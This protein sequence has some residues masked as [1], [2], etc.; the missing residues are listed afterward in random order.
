MNTPTV[1]VAYGTRNGSTEGIA[2]LIGVA[3]QN[4]G[5]AVA[6]W[7]AGEVRDLSGYDAVVLG[8]ALYRH[9][10]VLARIPVCL[11]SSGPLDDSAD[12]RDIPPVSQVDEAARRFRARGHV[13]F[14]GRLTE[15]A[16]GFVAKA[17]IRSGRGGDSA[18]RSGSRHELEP[19]P[20]TCALSTPITGRTCRRSDTLTAAAAPGMRMGGA[21]DQCSLRRRPGR[22]PSVRPARPGEPRRGSARQDMRRDPRRP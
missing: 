11:F 12:E 17:M 20:P 7:P 1:L 2:D 22:P 16:K 18:T 9:A 21:A 6:V 3:L 15:G 8:S 4:E 13:T 5:L 19:S 14:G 10:H